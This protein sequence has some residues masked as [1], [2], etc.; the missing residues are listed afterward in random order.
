MSRCS[1]MPQGREFLNRRSQ[2]RSLPGA[3]SEQEFFRA[4]VFVPVYSG[5]FCEQLPSQVTVARS[6]RSEVILGP[7]CDAFLAQTHLG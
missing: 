3:L 1:Y 5:T 7:E 4:L 6:A 2:V